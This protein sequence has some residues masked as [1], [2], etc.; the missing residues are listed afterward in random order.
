MSRFYD[1]TIGDKR[2]DGSGPN[3]LQVELAISQA[4]AGVTNVGSMVRIWGVPLSDIS[5]SNDLY[6]KQVVVKGGMRAG[7]PLA[8]P[9]QAGVLGGGMVSRAF[10]NWVGTEQ[11]LDVIFSGTTPAAASGGQDPKTP[12]ANLVLNWKKGSAL[13]GPLRQALQTAY[14]GFRVVVDVARLVAPS[15]QVGFHGNVEQ[16]S[17]YL[18]RYTQMLGGAG[19]NG[20]GV[21][22]KNGTVTASDGSKA[23]GRKT[24]AYTDLVGQPTWIDQDTISIKMVMRGDLNV[25]DVVTL[26]RTLVTNTPGGGASGGADGSLKSDL[27]FQ[28]DFTIKTLNHVGNSRQPS[29]EAWVTVVE[30]YTVG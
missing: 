1:I 26:P 13:E 24:L 29:A 23:S 21:V 18:R 7:L 4:S 14:P 8:N 6:G 30:A 12:T 9:A 28:G 16:F 11:T 27:T 5:Q 20:V 15:D 25:L 10:G 3:A 22:V 17:H 2:Y 19:S